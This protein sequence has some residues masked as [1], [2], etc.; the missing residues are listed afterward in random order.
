MNAQI[1]IRTMNYDFDQIASPQSRAQVF[2]NPYLS[3][4]TRLKSPSSSPRTEKGC[5]SPSIVSTSSR[6]KLAIICLVISSLLLSVLTTT[7]T[8]LLACPSCDNGAPTAIHDSGENNTFN[9]ANLQLQH[10][11]NGTI[12]SLDFAIIGFP[13]TGTTSLLRALE[14]HPEIVMPW[15][16]FCQ[17]H[18][19]DGDKAMLKWLHRQTK[20]F[21]NASLSSPSSSP[22]HRRKKY[23]IKCPAMIRLPNAI[24]NLVK[25]SDHTRLVVGVR[26]P[27]LWFQSFYN[28]RVWEH[29]ELNLTE[30]IPYPS[31]LTNGDK[32]W[33]VVSTALAKFE[34]YLQQL[35][36]VPLSPS[37]KNDMLNGDK[38]WPKRMTPNPYKVFIYIDE[39]LKDRNSTRRVEFQR[40]LQKFLRLRTPMLD[41]GKM[42]KANANTDW[43]PDYID[44]CERRYSSI[45]NELLQ[46]AKKT[47]HWIRNKFIESDDVVVSGKDL[48]LSSLSSWNED[49]CQHVASKASKKR[50]TKQSPAIRAIEHTRMSISS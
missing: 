8:L 36:K 29:Y 47:S 26:N 14:R 34:V 20:A 45:R 49:P 43:Y 23:G 46:Q 39:Q 12:D 3:P 18:Q 24:D 15:T 27:I 41:F 16:E 4:T 19:D 33:R 38:F 48:F 50:R 9:S 44:I 7:G 21:H 30:T 31:E 2:R 5:L 10:Q 40:D 32:H 25:I 35:D 11:N 28:Y 22:I 13:K 6:S 17:I 42:P 37:E 1:T